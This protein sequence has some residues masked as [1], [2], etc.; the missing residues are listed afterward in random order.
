MGGGE[1][2]C[3]GAGGFPVAG[4]A[5]EG[6]SLR[7]GSPVGGTAGGGAAGGGSLRGG[8]LRGGSLRGGAG[9]G[10]RAGASARE[11]SS[12]C[13]RPLLRRGTTRIDTS[14]GYMISTV[15][16]NEAA[17][18]IVPWSE[19]VADRRAGPRTLAS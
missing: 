19:A 5:A 12:F 7:G 16:Q 2:G 6:G 13:G 1:T 9:A 8:P 14:P 17:S 10:S 3:S 18:R 11:G 4:D 15:C